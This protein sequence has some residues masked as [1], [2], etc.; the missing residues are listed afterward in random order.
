MS[1]EKFSITIPGELRTRAAALVDA[2]AALAELIADIGEP[3]D[4]ERVEARE[5]LYGAATPESGA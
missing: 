4:A 3:T 2:R 5:A 1:T